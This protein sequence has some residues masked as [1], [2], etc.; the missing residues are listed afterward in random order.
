MCFSHLSLSLCAQR[1]LLAGAE[2]DAEAAGGAD[3]RHGA[4][5]GEGR[6]RGRVRR[7]GGGGGGQPVQ[8]QTS[9]PV[10]AGK[11]SSCDPG[12]PGNRIKKRL[13]KKLDAFNSAIHLTH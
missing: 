3:H 13:F 7:R 5:R 9:L 4:G 1:T 6:H 11:M 12:P 2:G 10:L 8:E